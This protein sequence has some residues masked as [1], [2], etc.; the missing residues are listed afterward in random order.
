MNH[1]RNKRKNLIETFPAAYNICQDVKGD[2]SC[3]TTAII[4]FF[5]FFLL[6]QRK[7]TKALSNIVNFIGNMH[8]NCKYLIVSI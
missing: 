1:E 6:F 4:F 8:N 3:S 2:V 7:K 5:F